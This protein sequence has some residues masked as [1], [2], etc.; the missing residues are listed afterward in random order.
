MT[1]QGSKGAAGNSTNSDHGR[2]LALVSGYYGFGNLGDEAILEELIDELKQFFS[3]DQIYVLSQHPEKTSRTFGVQAVNRW[4][5]HDLFGLFRRAKLLV[6]GGGGLFQDSTSAKSC[7]YYS[8][9]IAQ[10][11]LAGAKVFVYAQGLGP[12]TKAMGR[13]STRFA[14]SLADLRSVRDPKSLKMLKDWSLS[15][16]QTADPVW[17]LKPSPLPRIIRDEL[18]AIREDSSATR[19][20]LVGVSLRE[21]HLVSQQDLETLAQ[22][23][24]RVFPQDTILT[25]LPLQKEQDA[26]V[27]EAVMHSWKSMGRPTQYLSCD[28]LEKPSQ[29]LE[30]IGQLDMVVGMRLHALLMALSAGTPIFGISYDPKVTHLLEEFRQPILNLTKETI[31]QVSLDGI[32]HLLRTAVN[33]RDSL[34]EAATTARESAKKSACQNIRLMARILDMQSDASMP[35]TDSGGEN[36]N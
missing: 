23:M 35:P 27:L 33:D 3:G 31:S 2:S 7:L 21:H 29:W 19:G 36:N 30:L 34:L 13:Q 20:R 11:K 5:L 17:C 8:A 14:M 22:A 16:E 10:A 12:L 28:A 26:H 15:A 9:V 18:A 24:A 32:A 1:G 6:S 4:R 25:P